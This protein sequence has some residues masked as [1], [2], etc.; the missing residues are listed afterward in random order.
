MT[1]D[2]SEAHRRN[3]E[4]GSQE[5]AAWALRL[6]GGFQNQGSAAA[7]MEL[8][9][10]LQSVSLDRRTVLLIQLVNL[11]GRVGVQSTDVA[12]LKVRLRELANPPGSDA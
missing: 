4:A 7:A 3:A 9:E 5:A 11:V 2:N 12:T 1:S 8:N 6:L 10:Y